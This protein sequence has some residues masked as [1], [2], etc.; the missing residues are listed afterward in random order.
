MTTPYGSGL[1]CRLRQR[2]LVPADPHNH[3]AATGQII[4]VGYLRL[5]PTTE[6][7]C[8]VRLDH[9]VFLPNGFVVQTIVVAPEDLYPLPEEGVPE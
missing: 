2:V 9:P 8:I 6:I 3:S 7:G 5:D 4:G 1:P